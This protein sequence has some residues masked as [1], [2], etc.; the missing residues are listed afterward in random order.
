MTID[1]ELLKR[2]WLWEELLEP[3]VEPL[4]VLLVRWNSELSVLTYGWQLY[5]QQDEMKYHTGRVVVR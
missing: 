1:Y 5:H 3:W 4:D 2:Q